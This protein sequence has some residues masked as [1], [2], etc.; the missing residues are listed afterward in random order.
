MGEKA[1]EVAKKKLELLLRDIKTINCPPTTNDNRRQSSLGI[2]LT[3]ADREHSFLANTFEEKR[4]FLINLRKVC[5]A[6]LDSFLKPPLFVADD[7]L[8]FEK[9]PRETEVS[10]SPQRR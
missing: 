2:E 9:Q 5:R 6:R 8:L 3:T 4:A 7:S 10:Q 1:S